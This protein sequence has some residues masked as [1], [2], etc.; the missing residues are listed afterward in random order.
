[1][2]KISVQKSKR[3]VNTKAKVDVEKFDEIKKA[4]LQVITSVITMDEVPGSQS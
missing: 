2:S 1:M 3:K 4:F